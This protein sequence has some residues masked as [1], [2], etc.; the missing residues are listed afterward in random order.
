METADTHAPEGYLSPNAEKKFPDQYSNAIYYSQK[1]AVKFIR[2]IQSQPFYENTT[3]F[4]IGDHLTMASVISEKVKDYQRTCFNLVLN[5]DKSLINLPENRFVNRQWAAFDM[6]PTMLAG[7]GVQI[8][9]NR[10]GIGTNLFSGE[11]TLFETYGVDSVNDSLTQKSEFYNKNILAK[12][13]S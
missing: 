12:P 8:K 5:P 10:L 11:K 6:F 3:V 1:E 2:W 4:I 13:N 7:I 9:D